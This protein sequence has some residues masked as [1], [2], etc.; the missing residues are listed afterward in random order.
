MVVPSP[1]AALELL[2][3][4]RSHAGESISAFELLHGQGLRFLADTQPD[5]RMPFVTLPEW[6]VLVELG[7]GA[8]ADEALETLFSAALE[9]DLVSDGMIAQNTRQRAEMWS[10]REH[11]PIANK[12]IGSVA[13]HDISLPLSAVPEFIIKASVQVAQMGPYRINCFGHLGDG[14]LH[15]N[16]FPPLGQSRHDFDDRR[17][18]VSVAIYDIV[19]AFGGS[20]SAEHGVGRMKTDALRH[21]GDPARIAAMQAVK[22]ALDPNGIMN[23]GVML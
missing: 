12:A 18:D 23:P 5:V 4:A 13:S 8:G 22:A 17:H 21:Y 1:Q 7:M 6:S 19:H 11:I 3:L 10:I 9:A 2:A 15:Y 16:I 20:F 14:N